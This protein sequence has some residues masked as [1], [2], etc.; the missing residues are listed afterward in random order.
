M[1]LLEFFGQINELQSRVFTRGSGPIKGFY[2]TRNAIIPTVILVSQDG[3]DLEYADDVYAVKL[4]PNSLK[5]LKKEIN[6]KQF[7]GQEVSESDKAYLAMIEL[8]QKLSLTGEHIQKIGKTLPAKIM[9][10]NGRPRIFKYMT[11]DLGM[12]Q[13]AYTNTFGEMPEM[14]EGDFVQFH[15]ARLIVPDTMRPAN[16]KIATDAL[17]LVYQHLDKA[18][19]IEVFGGDIRFMKLSS[20]TGGTYSI[21][22]Q[23]IIVNQNIKRGDTMQAVFTL[24]HEY[25]HKKMYEFM[26]PAAVA[27][28]KDKYRELRRGG[29]SHIED[30]DH[31]TAVYHA[32]SQFQTGQELY[33]VGRKR[34]FKRDPHY[35]ITAIASDMSR[36]SLAHANN[37]ERV[38]SEYPM[39]NLLNPKKWK[40]DGIDFTAPQRKPKHTVT[41][42]DWF[43]TQYSE[44]EDEEWWAEMYAL[45]TLGNLSGE[46]AAWMR[47]MLHGN[48]LTESPHRFS[49]SPRTGQKFQVYRN[50]DQQEWE[51]LDWNAR[52]YIVGND[53]LAWGMTAGIHRDVAREL[54]IPPDAIPV[55]VYTDGREISLRVTDASN[56][57]IWEHNPDV[58][59]AIE[60]SGY[61]NNFNIT[62]IDFWDS[63]IVGDWQDM[64]L[65]DSVGGNDGEVS[66]EGD[67]IP[68][69]QHG[70]E[71]GS[72][73]WEWTD[74]Y[75]GSGAENAVMSGTP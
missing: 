32:L 54:G 15:N 51:K 59:D 39:I 13:T 33:Y 72:A 31:A 3:S 42:S 45:Y 6:M 34:A 47:S 11:T 17:E 61:I 60:S 12:T 30:I 2:G 50:P 4:Q 23:T 41:S 67:P 8:F 25:G 38:V 64:E 73:G 20:Y 27:E 66:S 55:Y 37:P 16:V 49:R 58:V 75:H 10:L 28:V 22:N 5:K 18:G 36:A 9:E 68:P 74:P 52:G 57:T 71:E 53:L 48:Q 63:A 19:E 62:D 44:A 24:L 14:D 26:T 43:P 65:Y 7:R 40:A 56:G 69:P 1:K 70:D 29:E 21:T 46:P 35:V